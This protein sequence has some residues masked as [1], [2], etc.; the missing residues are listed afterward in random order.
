ME[1][2]L[3]KIKP[4][5]KR[6]AHILEMGGPEGVA[7]Q[8][9]LGKLTVRERLD[10]LFDKGTFQELGLFVRAAKT[11]YDIDETEFPADAL[12]AGLG[13][14]NGRP[15]SVTANDYTVLRGS[16]GRAAGRKASRMLEMSIQEKIPHI[17]INDTTSV[18][19]HDT[20]SKRAGGGG[21]GGT[22]GAAISGLGMRYLGSG[23]T[24]QISLMLG[25]M[26]AGGAYEP[27]ECDFMIMRDKIAWMSVTIP[28]VLKTVTSRDATREELGGG[29]VH[30]TKS[31]TADFLTQTDEEAIEICRELISYLPLNCSERPP[32]VDTGDDPNRRDGRLLEIVPGDLSKSYDMH[33]VIRCV[34][35]NGKFLE[36]AALYA[37]SMI[38]GFAR[39]NGRTVGIIANNPA[40]NEGVLTR[41]T[42]DKQARFIRFCDC[43]NIPLVFLV[44]TCGFLPNLDEEQSKDGLLRHAPRPLFAICEATVPMISVYIGK[45]FGMAHLVMGNLRMGVDYAYSWPSAQ[46][47]RIKPEEVVEAI[48]KK[49]INSSKEP[50]KVRKEKLAELL[51]NYIN[52]PYHAAEVIQMVDEI[53]DPRDTRSNLID[54]LDNLRNKEP[55]LFARKSWKKHSLM[56]R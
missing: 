40:E 37:K 55:S 32:F 18:R 8:H 20:Y 45:C 31:G 4:V 17:A 15:V 51:K 38:I 39:L 7:M 23:A 16:V 49:E 2:M 13:K 19:F 9:Q 10:L 5:E 54:M 1:N 47:A 26:P 46:V 36:V 21:S 35:D 25:P 50:D 3:D 14:I 34:A 52:Y 11:G 30:A 53:I 22:P 43:Y 41:N 44:D 12:I 48:Y 33:E 6:R 24:P 42:C 27:T 56:P 29:T 28:E